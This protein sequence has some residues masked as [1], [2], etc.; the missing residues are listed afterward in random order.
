MRQAIE[1][2]KLLLAE[3]D[4]PC[5]LLVSEILKSAN[6]QIFKAWDGLSAQKIY[7][8]HAAEIELVIID[9]CLPGF[10]GFELLKKIRIIN[11]R[12]TALALSALAPGLLTEKCE[13]AGFD[14]LISKPFDS[15]QF[16]QTVVSF[17]RKPQKQHLAFNY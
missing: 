9:I 6:V 3:D 1:K 11:P 4:E 15:G 2:R 13:I 8:R 12:I 16:Y 14:T 17:L 5:R 10:D 7:K